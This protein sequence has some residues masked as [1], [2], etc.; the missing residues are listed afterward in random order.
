M[1]TVRKLRNLAK[2]KN[3][4]QDI[5]DG[6]M[7]SACLLLKKGLLL[8]QTA[9][10]ALKN[11]EN[12]FN[13]NGFNNFVQQD[14]CS[15][16]LHN[17]ED[18]EKIYIT[19]SEQMNTKF[20][21]EVNN[22]TY[23]KE[24]DDYLKLSFPQI[25]EINARMKK[26]FQLFKDKVQFLRVDNNKLTEYCL[27]MVN[28]YYSILSE[29]KLAFMQQGKIFEWRIFETETLTENPKRVLAKMSF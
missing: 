22:E 20:K 25:D 10:H 14:D 28:F 15:S 8:N 27:T 24:L 13:L 5:S 2:M 19:F 17:Y 26:M 11:K 7:F 29:E 16:I 4:Y 3:Y 21:S 12:I 23:K 6:L 1:Y 18:D 9:I